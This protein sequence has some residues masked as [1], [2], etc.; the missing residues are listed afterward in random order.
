M[1]LKK[2]LAKI[3]SFLEHKNVDESNYYLAKD[4]EESRWTNTLLT[5]LNNL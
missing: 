4:K 5:I 2:F 3:A 1:S